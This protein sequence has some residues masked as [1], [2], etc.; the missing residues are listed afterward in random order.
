MNWQ[1]DF[2]SNANKFLEKN[3]LQEIA[4]QEI[5]LA[6]KKIQGEDVN[7][8]LKKLKG[9]WKGFYRIRSGKLRIIVEFHFQQQRVFVE[10]IEWRGNIYK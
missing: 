10:G 6:I 2:S 9:E 3:K 8:D 4:V 5:V 7:V 1:I